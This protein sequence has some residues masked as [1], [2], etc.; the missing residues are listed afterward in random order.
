MDHKSTGLWIFKRNTSVPLK[1]VKICKG[2]GA[3]WDPELTVGLVIVVPNNEDAFNEENIRPSRIHF[4]GRRNLLKNSNVVFLHSEKSRTDRRIK[5][6]CYIRIRPVQPK[7]TP[8][9]E[10]ATKTIEDIADDSGGSDSGL[11]VDI[12]QP[13]P[14][15]KRTKL[16]S[17]AAPNAKS[18]IEQLMA[19]VLA[20]GATATNSEANLAARALPAQ[21]THVIQETASIE[22][23]TLAMDCDDLTMNV[24]VHL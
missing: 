10:F 2:L 23:P 12:K 7:T 3:E 16:N 15:S 4:G 18:L 17:T 8:E 21:D 14:P 6:Q 9:P 19:V 22:A 20:T 13:Q 5:A 24:V 1:G 11:P